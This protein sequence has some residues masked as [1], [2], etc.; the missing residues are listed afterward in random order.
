LA[1]RSPNRID[2]AKALEHLESLH[3]RGRGVTQVSIEVRGR[4][5]RRY[6][7]LYAPDNYGKLIE[8]LLEL[9]DRDHRVLK[10]YVGPN[11]RTEEALRYADNVILPGNEVHAKGFVPTWPNNTYCNRQH[12]LGDLDF[13]TSGR[14]RPTTNHEH[15]QMIELA[16]RLTDQEPLLAGAGVFDSGNN[17]YFLGELPPGDYDDEAVKALFEVLRDRYGLRKGDRTE[18]AKLDP[19]HD[20]YHIMGLAGTLKTKGEQASWRMQQLLKPGTV[21]F[22]MADWLQTWEP[23]RRPTRR[24]HTARRGPRDASDFDELI[25]GWC[26]AYVALW[27][28]GDVFDRSGGAFCLALK[29][30]HDGWETDQ[31]TNALAEWLEGMGVDRDRVDRVVANTTSRLDSPRHAEVRPTHRHVDEILGDAPC[32]GGCEVDQALAVRS[33]L[34]EVPWTHLNE[35]EPA[36]LPTARS[37]LQH[38]YHCDLGSALR[39]QRNGTKPDAVISKSPMGIGKSLVGQQI[40]RGVEAVFFFP[41]RNETDRFVADSQRPLSDRMAMLA[42]EVAEEAGH[43]GRQLRPT[44]LEVIR[45][46][47]ECCIDAGRQSDVVALARVHPA[48]VEKRICQDC[49]HYGRTCPYYLQFEPRGVPTSYVAPTVWARLRRFRRILDRVDLVVFD[50]DPL[51]D[52]VQRTQFSAAA[53]RSVAERFGDEDVAHAIAAILDMCGVTSPAFPDRRLTELGN[54]LWAR[55]ESLLVQFEQFQADVREK[56][57]LPDGLLELLFALRGEPHALVF[58]CHHKATLVR[59]HRFRANKPVLVL[60]GTADLELYQHLFPQHSLVRE[61][62]PTIVEADVWQIYDQAIP[63]ATITKGGKIK[64]ARLSRLINAI[65]NRRQS[66]HGPG[67][68]LIGKES[69]VD[70]LDLDA[71]V[72][73]GHY[74]KNRGSRDFE[75]CHTMVVLGA[76]EPNPT[77]LVIDARVIFG[78]AVDD[79]REI[80]AVPYGA[81]SSPGMSWATELELYRDPRLRA[82]HRTRREAEMVQSAFRIRPLDGRHKQIIILSKIPLP[83]L[84]PSRL[85]TTLELEKEFGLAEGSTG[86]GGMVLAKREQLVKELRRKPTQKEIKEALEKDGISISQQAISKALRKHDGGLPNKKARPK[87]R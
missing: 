5:D 4:Q 35:E 78:E 86:K 21:C 71:S 34:V 49:V 70:Q 48:S 80:V 3:H 14:D 58:G 22:A 1:R 8:D 42:Y 17:A 15:Q 36:R 10:F 79:H 66:E 44:A 53:L 57:M 41:R 56:N 2:P 62:S 55:R 18:I 39:R 67:V 40:C 87:K 50:E 30:Y 12:V 25:A 37:E 77:D 75:D 63:E 9:A 11:P 16:L 38:G 68:A 82:L 7:G 24:Q 60:D 69:V 51:S 81:Q 76:A 74:W 32:L 33:R 19:S 6:L 54:G 59:F 46:R 61:F 27:H 45:R 26:P 29:M 84:P 23:P 28:A 43:P 47:D 13:E 65:A 20:R 85:F 64:T 52:A 73:R 83:G 31:I 72:R